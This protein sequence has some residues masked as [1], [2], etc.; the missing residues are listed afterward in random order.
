MNCIQYIASFSLFN[1]YLSSNS[2]FDLLTPCFKISHHLEEC[3]CIIVVVYVINI[4]FTRPIRSSFSSKVYRVLYVLS[5]MRI[6]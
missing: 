4:A 3:L 5:T 2:Y 6:E 1:V